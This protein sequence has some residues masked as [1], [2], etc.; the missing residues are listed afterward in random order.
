MACVAL[1]SAFDIITYVSQII[2]DLEMNVA[3]IAFLVKRLALLLPGI[4]KLMASKPDSTILPMANALCE[5][6]TEARDFIEQFTKTKKGWV[7]NRA[8][9]VSSLRLHLSI[10]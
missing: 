4:E 3:S 6:C 8:R 1:Q 9:K 2:K 10:I 7:V 5:C